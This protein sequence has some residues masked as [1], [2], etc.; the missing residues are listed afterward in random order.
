ML[1]LQMEE[2]LELEEKNADPLGLHP[3][4]PLPTSSLYLKFRLSLFRLWPLWG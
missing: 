2:L 1:E 4:P 3:V